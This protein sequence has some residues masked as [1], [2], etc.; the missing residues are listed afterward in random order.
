MYKN[1]YSEKYILQVL[2]AL[3]FYASGSYQEIT[4]S[5]SFIAISQASMSRCTKEVTNALNR[6][7]ILSRIVHYPSTIE[8]LEALRTRQVMV[9]WIMQIHFSS[10]K[11]LQNIRFYLIFFTLQFLQQIQI[12]RGSRMY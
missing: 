12:S 6:R 7:E 1:V 11:I 3:R 4:G 2:A 5:N 10:Y 8:E 9:R